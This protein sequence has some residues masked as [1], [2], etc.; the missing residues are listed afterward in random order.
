M[1]CLDLINKTAEDISKGSAVG[2]FQGRMEF[3]PRSLGARSILADPRS[4]SMQKNLN[5]K[6]EYREGFSP[7]GP[8]ILSEDVSE[9]FDINNESPYMLMVA[10]VSKKKC[11]PMSIEEKKFIWNRET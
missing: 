11:I 9:W 10:N 7:F 8:S 3:G 6:V 4:P 1:S 2:W 5:L